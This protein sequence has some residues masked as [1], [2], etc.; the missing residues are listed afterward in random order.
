MGMGR[1]EGREEPKQEN[2]MS[3]ENCQCLEY[4]VFMVGDKPTRGIWGHLG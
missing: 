1:E 4:L 3:T 2:S